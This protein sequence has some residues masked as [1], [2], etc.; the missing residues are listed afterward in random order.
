MNQQH[1]ALR[2][3]PPVSCM[4]YHLTLS[5][6][7][8][9]CSNHRVHQAS[10]LFTRQSRSLLTCTILSAPRLPTAIT[11]ASNFLARHGTITSFSFALDLRNPQMSH[12]MSR[13][14]LKTMIEPNVFHTL[15]P[16]FSL[17]NTTSRLDKRTC[18]GFA[19][20]TPFLRFS[21]GSGQHLLLTEISTCRALRF[22]LLGKVRS[23]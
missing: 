12:N 21:P 23:W 18:L 13:R 9:V 1:H 22:Y 11:K 20:L 15:E 5:I 6:T 14:T 8:A 10:P 2:S 3:L 4:P 16:P 17:R 7:M 19:I